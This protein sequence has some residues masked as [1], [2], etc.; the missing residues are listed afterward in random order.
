VRL[1]EA[2]PVTGGL[3]FNVLTSA[4]QAGTAAAPKRFV[5]AQKSKSK[6][7]R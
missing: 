4:A 2:R 6:R 5:P 3:I 7:H 1:A